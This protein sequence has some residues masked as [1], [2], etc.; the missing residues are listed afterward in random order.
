MKKNQ[1]SKKALEYNRLVQAQVPKPPIFWNCCK[2][3]L[4]GGLIC[5]FAQ[6]VQFC[7]IYFF[8]FS[9]TN[10]AN[11]TGAVM[12]ILAIIL[13]CMGVYDKISQ[14]AGAGSAVP[15]T[16]F[17]NGMASAALEYR[18]EGF[19]LG[20][21]GNM[22]KVAGPVIVFGVVAAFVVAIIRYIILAFIA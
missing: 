1:L 6:V 15:I 13:T 17:A 14:W 10:A 4:V 8:D 21:G 20:V 12:I 2:A 18:S 11:P 5:A 9:K 7:F 3:F 19:V 16:G 22:F